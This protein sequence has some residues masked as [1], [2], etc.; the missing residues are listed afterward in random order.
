ME[1]A[2]LSRRFII[3]ESPVV[4]AVPDVD[5]TIGL[6]LIWKFDCR[7]FRQCSLAWELDTQ[8]QLIFSDSK[9]ST[10]IK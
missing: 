3:S 5:L 2:E 7:L 4:A 8:G 9:I 1:L 10:V 6:I